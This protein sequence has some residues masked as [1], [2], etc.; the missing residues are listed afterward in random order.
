MKKFLAI[1]A[2]ATFVLALA[3]CSGGNADNA[4]DAADTGASD[5]NAAEGPV[6]NADGT[7]D[8]GF[9]PVAEEPWTMVNSAEEAAKEADCG[10]FNVPV[11]V[12]AGDIGFQ[13][14]WFGY[15]DK[16]AQA[17][18]E[19]PACQVFIL[20]AKGI[21]GGPISDREPKEFAQNWTQNF[22]GLELQCYGAE[23]DAATL[24][25]WTIDDETYSLT[26]Q[27]LGGEE[28]S[29]TPDEVTSIVAEVS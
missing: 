8:Y 2:I 29:F 28:M 22:K 10:T 16:V 24:V 27:G 25:M 5:T 15:A 4:K 23:K 9:T 7:V 17:M 6:K 18:Y 21:Y 11:S 20:K 26:F 14:P 19:A 13:A 12:S 3:G 1:I